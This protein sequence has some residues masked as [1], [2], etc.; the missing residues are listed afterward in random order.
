MDSSASRVSP[1]WH[2]NGLARSADG[3]LA[4]GYRDWRCGKA[5]NG[6]GHTPGRTS[7]Q[8]DI[9]GENIMPL[10]QDI[11]V[12]FRHLSIANHIFVTAMVMA[13]L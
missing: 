2:K 10:L 12:V 11:T 4:Y 3:V 1:S 8:R 7:G 9:Y 5:D 13:V 6:T